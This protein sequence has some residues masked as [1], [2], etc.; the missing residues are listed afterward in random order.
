MEHRPRHGDGPDASL[1]PCQ[2]VVSGGEVVIVE[3]GLQSQPIDDAASLD[4]EQLARVRGVPA[5]PGGERLRLPEQYPEDRARI[6]VDRHR[7]W[8]S[9]RSR[10]T[11]STCLLGFTPR[12]LRTSPAGRCAS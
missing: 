10:R 1:D 5:S 4:A 3:G 2:A 7:W 11:T 6:Q 12:T 9:S 8:R